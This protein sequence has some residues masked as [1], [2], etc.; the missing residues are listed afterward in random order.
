MRKR[1]SSFLL[2]LI[3]IIQILPVLSFAE[4]NTEPEPSEEGNAVLNRIQ[5]GDY[6]YF[7][8]FWNR[9]IKW[10]VLDA[11]AMSTGEPGLFLLS[12]EMLRN[13]GVTY[14]IEQK[15]DWKNS[16]A[17]QWCA[18]MYTSCFSARE[19]PLVAPTT[20]K[21]DGGVFFTQK[22][23]P[24]ELE[25][26]YVF[27]LSADEAAHYIGPNNGDPDLTAKAYDGSVGYWWLRSIQGEKAGLVVSGNTVSSDDLFKPWGAR[28]AIN[29]AGQDAMYVSPANDK[30]EPGELQVLDEVADGEWKLTIADSTRL[31][32]VE[33]TYLHNGILTVAY[34]GA[35]VG[36]NE[37][38]SALVYDAEGQLH[39]YGRLVKP[40]K[41]AGEFSVSLSD[42]IFPDGGSLYLFSEQD[43]GVGKTDYAGEL[44]QVMVTIAFDPGDGSGEMES[45]SLP[46]GDIPE[47]VEP[48]FQPPHGMYFD[49]WA[50]EE[51]LFDQEMHAMQDGTLTA[52]YTPAMAR[53]IVLDKVA[54]VLP[55]TESITIQAS[56][57]PEDAMDTTVYWTGG[58][59]IAK[60]T[61]NGDG[62]C[63]IEALS[64]GNTSVKAVSGDGRAE[65]EVPVTVT[66]T[67]SMATISNYRNYLIAGAA[68]LILLVLLISFLVKRIRIH[69]MRRRLREYDE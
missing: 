41:A 24:S 15:A 23:E 35:S 7:G 5:D 25:K 44:H 26:D 40:E 65:I 1:L 36:E 12:A 60:L 47:I 39:A 59:D 32:E 67:N 43:N 66:G 17:R 53:E 46:L 54:A 28:P 38:I 3:L 50:A 33:E 51:G 57:F 68:A 20:K 16:D 34:K 37:Y 2:S 22:W 27:F 18:D 30:A 8:E 21:D 9:N 69:R 55:I 4:E 52:L 31:F 6:L 58:D 11:D 10:K 42:F 64:P 19:I 63:T 62:S 48:D 56:V 61:D 49:R 45:I 14:S 29:L 13:D